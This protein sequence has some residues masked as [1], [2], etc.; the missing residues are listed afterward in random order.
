M[1]TTYRTAPTSCLKGSF[2]DVGLYCRA[3]YSDIS[4]HCANLMP[5]GPDLTLSLPELHLTFTLP[6]L[7][8]QGPYLSLSLPELHLTFTLPNL[9]PQG[10]PAEAARR[11]QSWQRGATGYPIVDAGMRELWET[12]WM[13]QVSGLGFRV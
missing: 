12:G 10:P 4:S 9:M 5:Q 11:L 1:R 8:P 13:C 3:H 7:M 2:A 6:K